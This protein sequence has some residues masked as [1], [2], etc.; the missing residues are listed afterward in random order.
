MTWKEKTIKY[1]MK[2]QYNDRLYC[3]RYFD[4]QNKNT[5]KKCEFIGIENK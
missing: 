2:C 3:K 1:C 4:W 5:I